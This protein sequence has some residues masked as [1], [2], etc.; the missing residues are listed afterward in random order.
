MDD[1]T[2][3][4]DFHA[5]R[6]TFRSLLAASG[7]HPKVAQELMRHSDINLTMSRYSHVFHGQEA[8]AVAKLPDFSRRHLQAN[9]ATGTDGQWVEPGGESYRKTYSDLTEK[10]YFRCQQS[11]S[12]GTERQG[13][14]AESTKKWTG[15]NSCDMVALGAK[16]RPMSLTDT[17]SHRQWAGLAQNFLM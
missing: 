5:L 13:K 10:V 9:K 7:I 16:K 12:G 2:G 4:L 15:R 17:G 3:N 1:E 11:A 6:H 14:Q 8:N